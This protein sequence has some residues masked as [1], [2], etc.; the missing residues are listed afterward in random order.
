MENKYITR[1]LVAILI[2]IIVLG[3]LFG[4][5]R[6]SEALT[7]TQKNLLKN[8][9]KNPSA[10]KN[11]TAETLQMQLSKLWNEHVSLTRE[12]IVAEFN[13]SPDLQSK[14]EALLKNQEDIGNFVDG[15]YGGTKGVVTELFKEHITG[16]KDIL[17]DLKYKRFGR[18]SYDINHWYVNGDKISQ[19]MR[20]I[21]PHWH[22]NS[23][24]NKHLRITEQEAVAE[25]IG[26][27]K[28]SKN[29][30]DKHVF[31]QGQEM[32]DMMYEGLVKDF[33]NTNNNS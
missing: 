21:N 11:N 13:D 4:W 5:F 33:S 24:F 32:A 29:I 31:P 6:K 15:Y 23:H 10:Y 27:K 30:Y 3:I 16:A 26:A 8:S 12:V 18:L 7:E 14:V 17:D 1:G 9:I 2:I 25:F 19:A 22:F 20:L 28:L